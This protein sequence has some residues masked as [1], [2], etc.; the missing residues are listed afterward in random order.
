M[1]ILFFLLA[2][3]IFKQPAL[4]QTPRPSQKEVKAQ[5]QEAKTG[6]Q[7]MIVELENQIAEAKIK[8]EDPQSITDMENQLATMKKMLGVIDEAG[9]AG[10]KRP[11]TLQPAKVEPKYVSP[12][13]PVALKQPVKVP[14]KEQAKD[15]LFWYIGKKID[16]NTL[17]TT[18][19]MIV[20]HDRLNNRIIVQ[21]DKRVDTPYYGL[22]STLAQTAKTKID[23]VVK[24][25]GIKNSFFMFPEILK[26]YEEFDYLKNT[27]YDIAKNTIDLP[28]IPI[29]YL[30]A[31]LDRMH[32]HLVAL[33]DQLNELVDN[34]PAITRETIL[35]AP[36]RPH[37]L[38][39]CD[40]IPLVAFKERLPFWVYDF[41]G[42][43]LK[44][45]S[46][47]VDMNNQM[48]HFKTKGGK[49]IPDWNATIFKAKSIKIDRQSQKLLILIEKYEEEENIYK[50]GALAEAASYLMANLSNFQP[51]L[52]GDEALKRQANFRVNRAKDIIFKKFFKEYIEEQKARENYT[53]VF[54][55]SLYAS[56]E[57]HKKLFDSKY[58]I[59]ENLVDIWIQGLNKFNRFTLTITMDFEFHF[60]DTEQK[61][62]MTADGF[63]R[64]DPLIVSLG[65]LDCKW[66]LYNK[67]VDHSDRNTSDETFHIP[68]KVIQG[69][70]DI[71]EDKKPPFYYGGPA[72]LQMIFPSIRISFCQDGSG[73]EIKD[74]VY[75]DLMRYGDADLQAFQ[76]TDY[77][78]E[79]T[80]DMLMYA[81]KMFMGIKETEIN[82]DK[83]IDLNSRMINIQGNTQTP[84]STG[85]PALDRLMIEYFMNLQRHR[86]QAELSGKSHTG[87]TVIP[88]DA[89]I[90]THVLAMQHHSTVDPNDK[91]REVGIKLIR[92]LVT[93]RVQHSPLP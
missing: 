44:L 38:C 22:V 83:L 91:D 29:E 68:I 69:K 3:C 36:E 88:F 80:T 61:I 71:I 53:V 78:K 76:N 2:I 41:Y 58:N 84:P 18:E 34:L 63:L 60:L 43:E 86:F 52:S 23:F 56:H 31:D 17:L 54:D 35:P 93:L 67:E 5:L 12:F 6:A 77:S 15:Q 4:A 9:T 79:Y 11:K 8:G 25:E 28:L 26:A 19:G 75:M 59:P 81:N 14:A 48:E 10:T 64:S 32:S 1:R 85:I 50:E 40:T 13:V 51:I 7:K 90:G 30:D 66:Q 49:S 72:Y 89:S 27:Y 82:T 37:N 73:G 47:I 24:M 57:Y 21:P 92:G 42:D 33:R 20:R 65:L 46:M 74:S 70:K 62:V 45:W 55:Y 87:E 16:I 39:L